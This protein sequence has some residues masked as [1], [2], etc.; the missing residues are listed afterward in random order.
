MHAVELKRLRKQLRKDPQF[1]KIGKFF[2]R[3]GEEL[4]SKG[5]YD[6][7]RSL[8]SMR[9]SRSLERGKKG[10]LDKIIE[11]NI[12]D[13]SYRSRLAEIQ[14]DCAKA[15]SKYQPVIDD[16][17]MFMVLEHQEALRGF[18]TAKGDRHEFVTSL[19]KDHLTFLREIESVQEAAKTVILDIDKA[20]YL[21]KN[22]L[23]AVKIVHER[24]S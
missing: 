11:A 24:K 9:S 5:L 19:C 12:Q 1:R 8:H 15:L 10:F 13:Q 2:D 7:I 17:V 6:E 21:Y 23:E 22:L 3:L 16:L 14:M 4:S 20:G 18:F